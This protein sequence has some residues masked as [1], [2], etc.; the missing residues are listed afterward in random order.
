MVND[1]KYTYFIYI[2]G[3]VVTNPEKKEFKVILPAMSKR[4]GIQY[5]SVIRK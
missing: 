4:I 5:Y 1:G 2:S 3:I